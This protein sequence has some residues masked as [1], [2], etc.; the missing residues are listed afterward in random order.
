MLCLEKNAFIDIFE[1]VHLRLLNRRYL[2][3][4]FKLFL[5]PHCRLISEHFGENR[6]N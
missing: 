5:F 3:A 6:V 1:V 4:I 2:V